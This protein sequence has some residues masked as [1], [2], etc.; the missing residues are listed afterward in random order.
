MR[1]TLNIDDDLL[2]AVKELARRE[3][4]TVGH[5]VSRLL[6]RSLTGGSMVGFIPFSAKPG[7]MATNVQ[8]NALRD[9]EGL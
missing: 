4:A 2:A 5:V 1:T 8:V 6:R 3:G 9:A 7:V